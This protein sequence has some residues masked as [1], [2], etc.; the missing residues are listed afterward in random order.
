LVA[1]RSEMVFVTRKQ[2]EDEVAIERIS[3]A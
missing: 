1:A 2:T 3:A